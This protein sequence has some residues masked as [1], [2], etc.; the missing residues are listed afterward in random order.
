MNL[1]SHHLKAVILA[2]PEILSRCPTSLELAI[3]L[4]R[5]QL[6]DKAWFQTV[7]PGYN[8]QVLLYSLDEACKA[9]YK[10]VLELGPLD[11]IS[12]GIKNFFG[13]YQQQVTEVDVDTK[14][15]N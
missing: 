14:G 4:K 6:T 10:P 5:T 1:D 15:S 7:Q 8:W 2:F 9:Y 13:R 3:L 11:R 12:L